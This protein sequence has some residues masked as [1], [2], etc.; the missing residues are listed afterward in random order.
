M[1]IMGRTMARIVATDD[2]PAILEIIKQSLA[3]HTVTTA[4]DGL[5]GL[6][7][8]QHDLPDLVI[9]DVS[10]P[11]MDGLAVCKT[12]KEAPATGKIP[13]LLLTGQGKMGNVEDGTRVGAD[14]YIVK[15]FSP[16]VLA[17]RVDQLL[18]RRPR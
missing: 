15:P 17:A 2:D 16:R 10:M 8:V 5:K 12:L 6:A 9:L 14:D 3:A 18:A 11:G 13:V 4:P 1:G 7:L